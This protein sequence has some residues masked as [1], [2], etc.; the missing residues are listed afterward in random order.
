MNSSARLGGGAHP[1]HEG[2]VVII[3]GGARGISA[4]LAGEL[5]SAGASVVIAGLL[6]DGA[7]LA[8]ELRSHGRDVHFRQTDIVDGA[9]DRHPL[10]HPQDERAEHRPPAQPVDACGVPQHSCGARGPRSCVLAA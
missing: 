9:R 4:T 1:R 10:V 6:E 3:T 8:E 2:R 7:L 5:A